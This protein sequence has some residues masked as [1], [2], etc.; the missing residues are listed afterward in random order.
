[1]NRWAAV[2]AGALALCGPV[3]AT[4]LTIEANKP[5][6]L[7]C[8]TQSV[9]VAPEAA[10]TKGRIRLRLEAKPAEQ[11][12]GLIGTWSVLDQAAEHTA[13]FASHHKAACAV[14]CELELTK[15]TAFQLWAPKRAAPGTLATGSELTVAVIDTQTLKLRAS[16]F[17][18]KDI[19]ALEQGDCRVAE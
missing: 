8:D 9:V 2:I 4:P 10:T 14:A 11:G 19:A 16:T 5:L 7:T 6:E 15:A 18:D 12:S 1:M 17:I 3:H 13:S